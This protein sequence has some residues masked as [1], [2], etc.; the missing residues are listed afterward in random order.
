[1]TELFDCFKHFIVSI[2]SQSYLTTLGSADPG[3]INFATNTILYERVATGTLVLGG[4]IV[5]PSEV[6]LIPPLELATRNRYPFTAAVVPPPSGVAPSETVL[7]SRLIATIEVPCRCGRCRQFSPECSR[8]CR[9]P[10]EYLLKVLAV[11]G[12][13][14]E[15]LL[16]VDDLSPF[17]GGNPQLTMDG[18]MLGRVPD[19]GDKIY[20]IGYTNSNDRAY[21]DPEAKSINPG[22][23]S[24]S[25]YTD[26]AGWVLPQLTLLSVP[27]VYTAQVGSAVL[28]KE[29]R[30]IGM[31]VTTAAGTV[32]AELF[33][34]APP[35]NIA[36]SVYNE[37]ALP[38]ALVS[39]EGRVSA[40]HVSHLRQF[41]RGLRYDECTGS[42]GTS[43]SSF[44]PVDDAYHGTYSR[45][46]HGYLGIGYRQFK[47]SD[48]VDN[49][50]FSGAVTGNIGFEYP[51]NVGADAGTNPKPVE[52]ILVTSVAGDITSVPSHVTP[53]QPQ[54]G[55]DGIPPIVANSPLLNL[56][57]P[58]DQILSFK[59][60][61]NIFRV[62]GQEDELAPG[63]FTS[64]LVPGDVITVNYIP[65]ASFPKFIRSS[66]L[67]NE[68]T[69][70]SIP[71]FMDFPYAAARRFPT[72][73]TVV[74]PTIIGFE[75]SI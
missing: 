45:Y 33:N 64:R 3:P 36:N 56:V 14:N 21:G 17:N 13:D 62:G 41:L 31:I 50:D 27:G 16:E 72:Y 10:Y 7:V 58:G 52:G 69:I 26:P 9:R 63:L 4:R 37:A 20:V 48:Y 51:I 46:I 75:P 42:L 61:D 67:S 5:C 54:A 39:G 19:D 47:G 74:P 22:Y 12:V 18:L 38:H 65:A 28:D 34:G 6:A 40:I 8:C 73:I 30:L 29:G 23:V 70:D 71:A 59:Y 24:R 15:A 1:M 49:I 32:V 53:G 43:C 2:K 60:N 57:R 68:I 66:K 55:V 35:S 11:G 44:I 25:Y